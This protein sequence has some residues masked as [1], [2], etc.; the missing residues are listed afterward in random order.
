[1]A[2]VRP[3]PARARLNL[4]R[5]A[6][7][8]LIGANPATVYRWERRGHGTGL[9]WHVARALNAL[10][11]EQIAQLSTDLARGQISHEQAHQDVILGLLM[12]VARTCDW[13]RLRPGM[14]EY[15]T[16]C[17]RPIVVLGPT[18]APYCAFCGGRR[19]EPQ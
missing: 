11:D 3:L 12:R 8:R 9:A 5:L 19:A 14:P 10:S 2:R 15:V 1:M 13:V 7:A 17:G 6:F 4:S 16:G 18:V